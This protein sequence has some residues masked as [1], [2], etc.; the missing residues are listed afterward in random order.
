MRAIVKVRV[1]TGSYLL[2]VHR[3][4]NIRM[5]GV[6]DACC[7]LWNRGSGHSLYAYKYAVL[8]LVKSV[9]HISMNSRSVSNLD[10]DR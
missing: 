3:K 1:L 2:Q 7:P 9:L 8:H 6:T 4:E 10:G 5:D